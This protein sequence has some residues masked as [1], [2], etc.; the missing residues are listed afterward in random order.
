MSEY[1][2]YI[3]ATSLIVVFTE[4]PLEFLIYTPCCALH[5]SNF[6]DCSILVHV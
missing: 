6:T 2:N 4:N 5:I 3:Q 1:S